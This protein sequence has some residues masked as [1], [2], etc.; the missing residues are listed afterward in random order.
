MYFFILV[1]F[2]H[3]IVVDTYVLCNIILLHYNVNTQYYRINDGRGY[4]NIA[5]IVRCIRGEWC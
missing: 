2:R 5:F 1:V 3:S 4:N